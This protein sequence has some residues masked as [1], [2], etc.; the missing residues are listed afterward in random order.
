MVLN[1]SLTFFNISFMDIKEFRKEAVYGN[2][3]NDEFHII[4]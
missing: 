2:C 3:F 1:P 4:L